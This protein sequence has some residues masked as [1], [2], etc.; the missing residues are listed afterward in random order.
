MSAFAKDIKPLLSV[1]VSVDTMEERLS[2]VRSPISA[3]SQDKLIAIHRPLGE[4]GEH[5]T[6]LIGLLQRQEK[7]RDVSYLVQFYID[8]TSP[9]GWSRIET[10][11]PEIYDPAAEEKTLSGVTALSGFHQNGIT[12]VFVQYQSPVAEHSA[13]VQLMWSVSR[14]GK[15]VW[16][17]KKWSH[18]GDDARTVLASVRQLS[19]HRREDGNHVVFG[20]THGYGEPEKGRGNEQFFMLNPKPP[21]D[22]VS[23]TNEDII[24][25]TYQDSKH[26]VPGWPGIELT[27]T[28]QLAAPLAGEGEDVR[29]TLLRLRNGGLEF[30]TAIEIPKDYL[31]DKP[32]LGFE[33]GAMT[34]ETPG[35][36]LSGARI[37]DAP[38]GPRDAL[39][40]HKR[41]GE[42]GLISGYRG[43]A[44]E[45]V[46]LIQKDGPQSVGRIC[47]GVIGLLGAQDSKLAIYATDP[48]TKQLWVLRLSN[49]SDS[50]SWTC[51]GDRVDE[52]TCPRVMP[53]GEE[54][55]TVAPMAE[56]VRYRSQNVATTSWTDVAL[57]V[58]TV[59]TDD[60][61]PISAHVFDIEVLDAND[62]PCI[63]QRVTLTADG[64]CIF[65]VA[66]VAHRVGPL[67]PV[68]VATNRMG[69]IRG[70]IRAGGLKT[71]ALYATVVGM[72]QV[73]V[74]PNGRISERLAGNAKGY[75]DVSD[76]ISALA[77]AAH[78][79]Q[80][81]GLVRSFGDAT[82][83][84]KRGATCDGKVRRS[85]SMFLESDKAGF[86][87]IDKADFRK[88]EERRFKHSGMAT[89]SPFAFIGD[90]FSFLGKGL[91][92]VKELVVNVLDA[93][94]EFL[95]NGGKQ[96]WT[97]T[98]KVFD[99][100]VDGFE[101]LSS[102][103]SRVFQKIGA[104]V[105]DIGQRILEAVSFIFDGKDVFAA[106][107]S[108]QSAARAV[109]RIG[110][111]T[112]VTFG[113]KINK[114]YQDKI[115]EIDDYINRFIR[116]AADVV[117]RR[118]E[119]NNQG[120]CIGSLEIPPPRALVRTNRAGSDV[121]GGSSN[122]LV[123][124]VP[125]QESPLAEDEMEVLTNFLKKA[126]KN[127]EKEI[128]GP[129]KE[130]MKESDVEAR[131]QESPLVLFELVKGMIKNLAKMAGDL[132]EMALE[133]LCMLVER[134]LGIFDTAIDIPFVTSLVRLWSGD[135][136]R[137]LTFFDILTLPCAFVGT[138]LWKILTGR[139]IVTP[140]QREVFCNWANQ[141]P[142]PIDVGSFANR[143][144]MGGALVT[145]HRSLGAA[146]ANNGSEG[147]KNLSWR[148]I[149][150][151]VL[152]GLTIAAAIFGILLIPAQVYSE[153]GAV[154]GIPEAP[155]INWLMIGGALLAPILWVAG[156]VIRSW[157]EAVTGKR[158][159]SGETMSEQEHAKA[160]VEAINLS[161]AVAGLAIVIPSLLASDWVPLPPEIK[162]NATRG[163]MVV[164]AL[165]LIVCHIWKAYKTV[166]ADDETG[167]LK[168][169]GIGVVSLG[170]VGC[171]F[172]IV[173]KV[174]SLAIH[175]W[176]MAER[177][178]G[179]VAAVLALGLTLT[180]GTF[181]GKLGTI[182]EGGIDY[183][184][185]GFWDVP[186]AV[187]LS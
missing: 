181:F 35:L 144:N 36:D 69:R 163:V 178:I 146:A 167:A 6:D 118:E 65:Y 83:K 77:P 132:L 21:R 100:I 62:V 99:S 73:S 61:V 8:A 93:G 63:E 154:Q 5:H 12:Y 20:V 72:D 71:P 106:N 84:A 141:T 107:D 66:G 110:E 159:P 57:A 45:Y 34:V 79:K 58:A 52:I 32:R 29:Y 97:F 2:I 111:V 31:H 60:V 105:K 104:V 80:V 7:S 26:E 142:A 184:R 133:L 161:C 145:P 164:V 87:Q 44:P 86:Q 30:H 109:F 153:L 160:V 14:K 19:I 37:F 158:F 126:Q 16:F 147:D 25:D 116:P 185:Y 39:L 76:K 98:T 136:N 129:L 134:A 128:E 170:I 148:K 40:V 135:A 166:S 9:S 1:N 172:D 152:N 92:E 103:L 165:F 182:V 157:L 75:K 124:N 41:N 10:E 102:F 131:L 125:L 140:G 174:A 28:Y 119:M 24:F 150:L 64:P 175:Y 187:D 27:A 101:A 156:L 46:S 42:L 95:V 179:S 151:G 94:V 18:K 43:D 56:T 55:F 113:K 120:F 54:L 3:D 51:L 176:L 186:E 47:T 177:A 70:V 162:F 96:I 168:V 155:L 78:R 130:F 143:K 68:T 117:N 59:A 122:H 108:I 183:A 173:Q 90:F 38:A 81:R 171:V 17:E 115:D 169:A 13:I 121:M 49:N 112:A 53:N 50:S 123:G 67:L 138:A 180:A 82:S 91:M 89:S 149:I 33:S 85:F 23:V 11:L 88:V 4:E 139:P 137:N 114:A 74:Q 127:Y 48:A 15:P 22:P